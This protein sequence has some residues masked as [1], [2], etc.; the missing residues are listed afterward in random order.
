MQVHLHRASR[1]RQIS[2]GL[3]QVC[4]QRRVVR[5]GRR[6]GAG[7]IGG[8]LRIEVWRVGRRVE[9]E[10]LRAAEAAR[11]AL[12][13]VV[14]V[15]A[16]AAL[17]RHDAWRSIQDV[18]S[19][20]FGRAQ[21]LVPL[22]AHGYTEGHAHIVRGGS[23]DARRMSSCDTAVFIWASS[24]AAARWPVSDEAE[25]ALRAA[26]RATVPRSLHKATKANKRAHAAKQRMKRV[27]RAGGK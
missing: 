7:A 4:W 16:S 26:M 10:A 23:K 11:K 25:A 13:F 18:A 8:G 20:S 14:I 21:W 19:S 22:H 1:A 5:K 9:P 2:K 3:A 27:G 24:A 15:G 12:L 17:K 6:G